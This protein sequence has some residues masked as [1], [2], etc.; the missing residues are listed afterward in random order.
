MIAILS[1]YTLSAVGII[2]TVLSIILSV[3]LTLVFFYSTWYIVR[4]RYKKEQK[5]GTAENGGT[6]K[7][8]VR[9]ETPNYCPLNEIMGYEFITIQHASR[10]QEK[11]AT[12][13]EDEADW[14]GTKS[15]FLQNRT[16]ALDLTSSQAEKEYESVAMPDPVFNLPQN[17][18]PV[19]QPKEQSENNT[20]QESKTE[21]TEIENSAINISENEGLAATI[22]DENMPWSCA[23]DENEYNMVNRMVDYYENNNMIDQVEPERLNEESL[24]EYK[25]NMSEDDDFDYIVMQSTN[26]VN[27]M[28]SDKDLLDCLD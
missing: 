25:D 19:E 26:K 16:S 22:V 7:K 15:P 1:V 4:G 14:A 9:P 20:V 3:I 10:S 18:K 13:V 11:K 21:R 24:N 17:R 28:M 8:N 5:T 23:L 6:Q 27:N 12:K 2:G